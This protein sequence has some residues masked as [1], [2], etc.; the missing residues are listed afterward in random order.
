MGRTLHSN[1]GEHSVY[2]GHPVTVALEIM[3]AYGGEVS[4]AFEPSYDYKGDSRNCPDAVVSVDVSGAGGNV[5]LALDLLS[6]IHRGEKSPGEAIQWGM[7]EWKR[8]TLVGGDHRQN[9]E[10]GQEQAE[11]MIWPL[12]D[13]I[14]RAMANG[15]L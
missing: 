2:P 14:Y 11:R 15:H 7:D 8:M 13:Q 1:F 4:K 3:L 12:L 10:A 5:Y 9:Y 6:F